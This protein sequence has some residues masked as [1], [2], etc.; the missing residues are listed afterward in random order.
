[1]INLVKLVKKK[2]EIH[3]HEKITNITYTLNMY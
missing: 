2:R 3:L 1:M